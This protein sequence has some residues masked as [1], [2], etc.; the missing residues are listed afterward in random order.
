MVFLDLKRDKY[1]CLDQ[2]QTRAIWPF[3]NSR[4]SDFE[5]Q[6]S[7]IVTDTVNLLLD[8]EILTLNPNSGKD[9]SSAYIERPSRELTGYDPDKKPKTLAKHIYYFLSSC[10]ISAIYLR[11]LSLNY[12]VQMLGKRRRKHQRTKQAIPKEKF[13]DLVG[14]FKSL[15]PLIFTSHDNCMF[16]SLALIE[17]LSHFNLYPCWV[18]GVKMGP[19]VAHCWVQHDDMTLNDSVDHVAAFTPIMAV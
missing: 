15:R 19:F 1:M 10:L 8:N 12:I 14:I 17:F 9:I 2:M 6:E 13:Q 18:F 16:H 11:L 3:L 5:V 7:T 4:S